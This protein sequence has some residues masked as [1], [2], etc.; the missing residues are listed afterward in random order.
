QF[1]SHL[2]AKLT[3][4]WSTQVKDINKTDDFKNHELPLARIKKIMKSDKD[5][6]KIS[7]EAPILFAKAC[8]ILILEMTHRSWIHT[9]LNKRRTLQRT[10]IINSLSKCETFDFLIDMLPR[11]E[12]K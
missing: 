2:D 12:I 10:D 3:N 11:E 9:E 1:Q 8:E 6:N 5:V 7:S 4:F